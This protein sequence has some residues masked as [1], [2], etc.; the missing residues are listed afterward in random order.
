MPHRE[1]SKGNTMLHS[2]TAM[3]LALAWLVAWTAN[4]QPTINIAPSAEETQPVQA[5][6]K[7]PSFTVFEVNGRAYRFDP[8]KLERPTMLIT[9]RGGWCPVCNRHL[10]ALRELIPELKA[11]GFDILFLSGDRPELLYESLAEEAQS[12]DYTVLSDQHLEAA[13][14]LGLAFAVDY[15]FYKSRGLDL[16]ETTGTDHHALPVPAVYIVDTT[17]IIEFAHAEPDYRQ[18][19]SADAIREAAAQVEPAS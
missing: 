16:E 10:M 11:K 2:K 13:S 7:A 14:A 15:E 6:E 3:T 8:E 9:Y 1:P 17:G 4:A 19:L 18:R 12:L 5:G